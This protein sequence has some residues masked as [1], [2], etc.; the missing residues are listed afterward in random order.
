MEKFGNGHAG[1]EKS[2]KGH[3]EGWENQEK[4]RQGITQGRCKQQSEKDEKRGTKTKINEDKKW[5]IKILRSEKRGEKYLKL[6]RETELFD[7]LAEEEISQVIT[8]PGAVV[9]KFGKEQFIYR[10]GQKNVKAAIVLEGRVHIM[11]ED[12]WGNRS[13]LAEAGPGEMFAETYSC[14][15][16]EPL[17]VSVAAVEE[18]HCLF[19]DLALILSEAAIIQKTRKFETFTENQ[20]CAADAEAYEMKER[21]RKEKMPL[22]GSPDNIQMRLLGNIMR[23][24]AQKNLFLSKKAEFLSQRTTRQKLLAYLS[25]V[26]RKTGRSSFRI[27]FNRQQLADFLSVDRSAMSAELSKLQKE[28]ILRYHKNQFTLLDGSAESEI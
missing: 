20:Y 24:L 3:A 8:A 16:N 1:L 13:I 7:G 14:L 27:P 12:F 18:C 22:P 17:A 4:L 11:K 21:N 5:R 25:D 2:G 10:E 15:G 26:R 9:Q 19:L 6:L 23:I 28:G